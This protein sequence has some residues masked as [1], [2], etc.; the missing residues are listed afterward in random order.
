MELVSLD[1]CSKRSLRFL[2]SRGKGSVSMLEKM[3]L[4]W[5]VV[6]LRNEDRIALGYFTGDFVGRADDGRVPFESYP[7]YKGLVSP[8]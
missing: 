3:K 2:F 7:R 8:V 4:L 5:L 6:L 1:K